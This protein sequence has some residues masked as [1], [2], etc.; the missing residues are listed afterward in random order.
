MRIKQF[1]M[2][3]REMAVLA[4]HKNDLNTRCYDLKEDGYSYAWVLIDGEGVED[5]H[6]ELREIAM[7][8]E[9]ELCDRCFVVGKDPC[10]F[11]GREMHHYYDSKHKPSQWQECP[12]CGHV[13]DMTLEGG[14]TYEG[15]G[16]GEVSVEGS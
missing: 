14:A 3:P 15:H 8:G 10:P 6:L 16:I 7:D 4:T 2:I 12:C 9:W 11:C 5:D 13:V 1:Q